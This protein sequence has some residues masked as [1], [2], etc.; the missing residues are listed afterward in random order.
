MS[1]GISFTAPPDLDGI[2]ASIAAAER[3]PKDPK[4][5]GK[6]GEV[7]LFQIMPDT[8]R[9]YGIDPKLLTNPVVNRYVA[10]RYLSDLVREFKGN[11]PLAVA[12]YNAGPTR[13][14]GGDIPDSTRAYVRKVLGAGV[15]LKPA[16]DKIASTMMET[17]TD[18][19]HAPA[20]AIS[21]PKMLELRNLFSGGPAPAG[22]ETIPI[23]A[24]ATVGK[25]SGK[26]VPIPS[27]AMFSMPGPITAPAAAPGPQQPFPVKAATYLPV[28]GQ[29]AGELG[30]GIG[31][32][33]LTGPASVTGVPEYLGA[34]G[35]GALGSAGGAELENVIRK[36]YGYPP[37]SVGEEAAVGGL[38][39]GVGGLL[40]F[41]ARF[42]KAAALAK[43][44]GINF[45]AALE[46]VTQS[47]AELEG[48]LGLGAR[49]GKLLEG[50]P[51]TQA[52]QGYRAGKNF[53]LR[54]LGH[55]YD[56]LLKQYYHRMTPNSLRQMLD[57]T[58][59]KMLKLSGK[60]LR[61]AVED[62]IGA[63]P[64]TVRREQI[65][66]SRIRDIL[67][68]L[69]G[70]QRAAA[71]PL[72]QLE[73]AATNDIKAVIGP[74]A[75]AE[76]DVIDQ[77]FARQMARFPEPRALQKA[78]SEPAAAQVIL[79][80]GKGDEARLVDMIREMKRSGQIDT[81]RRAV[82]TRIWQQASRAATDSDARF[83][84]LIKVVG[85]IDSTVFDELYGKGAQ[86]EWID[87]ARLIR[88]R[89]E[90]L[91]KHP[92]EGLAIK[93]EVQ[94][95]LASPGMAARLATFMGYRAVFDVF[96]VAGGA[97][98]GQLG[99]GIGSAIAIE[100]YEMAMHS[101]FAMKALEK[102]ATEKT[103]RLAAR[104]FVAFVDAAVHA[105]AEYQFADTSM[106]KMPAAAPAPA[107]M[108][109]PGGP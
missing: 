14:K 100:I 41:V 48:T 43:S 4:A 69:S 104:A 34:T 93:A 22:A 23:P 36:H 25:P 97:Y 20:P 28:A 83:D 99:L 29:F 55:D 70:E 13:V 81:L 46:K 9:Q 3:A 63:K 86:K 17:Q 6:K 59:G 7:G 56:D 66:R 19:A 21:A 68:G 96:L 89:S 26:G 15:G 32:A 73:K 27:G 85:K 92:V 84:T 61:Q 50:A 8:A 88:E 78:Y 11:I 106:P 45:R 18:M 40:P 95:Y 65:I 52:Q 31:A 30:G 35:G 38:T 108:P 75:G 16:A 80:T 98:E 76:L 54:E 57:G 91:L 10:K 49:K 71:G 74:A 44:T 12:A 2:L 60:S 47:E 67:R 107:A 102:F 42:R 79:K 62:E 1:Q 105:G 72:R 90:E 87:T 58:V 103:P 37:V 77:Y 5:K 64:M 101:P 94:K 24:G 39:S 33:A 109:T 51:A 53:G 82:A